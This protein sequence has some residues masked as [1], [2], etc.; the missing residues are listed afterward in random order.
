[1]LAKSLGALLRKRQ[2]D[3][4]NPNRK[5]KPKT[6][7]SA[8]SACGPMASLLPADPKKELGTSCFK[9]DTRRLSDPKGP[10][11]SG[12]AMLYVS[13]ANQNASEPNSEQSGIGSEV[14]HALFC[15]GASA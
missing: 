11:K 1:M 7:V 14:Y 12:A 15:V 9:D 5:R 10:G 4:L 3:F 6:D 8:A 13:R 2:P